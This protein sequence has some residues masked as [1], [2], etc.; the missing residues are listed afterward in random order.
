MNKV[1]FLNDFQND[2]YLSFYNKQY[3]IG[4]D[5][6]ECLADFIG[7]VTEKYKLQ[8]EV[9]SWYFTYNHDLFDEVK[10]KKDFWMNLKTVTHPDDLP[11]LPVCYISRRS[12]PIEWTQEWLYNHG[13][14]CVPVIHVSGSKINICKEWEL[15]YYIDDSFLNFQELNANGVKTFLFDKPHN[16]KFKVGNYRISEIKEIITKI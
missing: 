15:D 8:Y 11:F 6:D 2:P 7:G 14:P 13:F 4:L 10:D 9:K 1:D 3:K 16:K 5:I 12:I